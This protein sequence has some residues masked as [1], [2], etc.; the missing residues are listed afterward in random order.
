MCLQRSFQNYFQRLLQ[1]YLQGNRD[2]E[3]SQQEYIGS[4]TEGGI[5]KN[6]TLVYELMHEI[7][8]GM[9]NGTKGQDS[10][11]VESTSAEFLHDYIYTKAENN[12]MQF[13][14]GATGVYEGQNK[15][16]MMAGQE[17]DMKS[18]VGAIT[19]K[20]DLYITVKENIQC[21]LNANVGSESVYYGQS[22]L[23]NSSIEGS[24]VARNQLDGRPRFHIHLN[25]S[26]T[27]DRTGDMDQSTMYV[28][29]MNYHPSVDVEAFEKEHVLHLTGPEGTFTVMNYRST[30]PFVPPILVKPIVEQPSEYRLEVILKITTNFDPSLRCSDLYVSFH[31][32]RITSSCRCELPEDAK[33]QTAEYS[34]TKRLVMWHIADVPGQQ[35]QFLHVIITLTEQ[36]G[37]FTIK[38]M[39]PI[40]LNF[41]IPNM[42]LSG[43]GVS[44]V[45]VDRLTSD[46]SVPDAHK[47]INYTVQSS[48][49]ICRF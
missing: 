3:L 5:R 44:A 46:P 21:V 49:Y 11:Y 1:F 14:V 12:Q 37:P 9:R 47:W 45:E 38:S 33:K 30:R 20:S 7:M 41:T 24:L 35:D 17:M 13:V 28:D 8:V 4:L 27:R 23:M 36:C 19:N 6:A 26:V 32:P 48:S 39:G 40:A 31:T 25:K 22:D 42:S 15:L 10:G 43:M 34:D 2:K 18:M 29:D 16:Q